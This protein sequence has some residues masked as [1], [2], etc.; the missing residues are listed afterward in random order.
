ME[1]KPFSKLVSQ[2]GIRVNA[3]NGDKGECTLIVTGEGNNETN[4]LSITTF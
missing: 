4:L 2:I 3:P 1:T